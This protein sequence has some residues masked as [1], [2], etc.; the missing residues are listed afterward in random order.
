MKL[1]YL[2]SRPEIAAIAQAAGVDRIFLDMETLDKETRQPGMD[3]VKSQNSFDD[4]APM[5]R[6]LNRT[7][8]LVRVNHLYAGSQAEIDRAMVDGADWIMLPYFKTAQEADAFVRMVDG[9]CKTVL[10][11]ETPEAAEQLDDILAVPGVD[12]LYI[13]LN[14]LHLGYGCRFL[15]ELLADGTVQRL[16]ERIAEA[17]IPY[18]FGG[19]GRPGG[20]A[21]M[22]SPERI[23]TE[24]VRLG[25][26]CVI[27][28]RSFC[29]LRYHDARQAQDIFAGGV[30]AVR[31]HLEQALQLDAAALEGNRRAVVQAVAKIVANMGEKA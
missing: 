13:G 29:D 18:G 8:L 30:A 11:L 26:Q 19:V 1:M 27:L 15:F 25:S 23:L 20:S 22:L 4:I 12:E 24:H 6:V 14:D 3:T 17:G 16:C 28:S 10:L 21:A 5:R 31:S 9:R 7:E 2:T